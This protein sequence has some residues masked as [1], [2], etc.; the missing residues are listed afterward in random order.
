MSWCNHHGCPSN[1]CSCK[2]Y[3]EI[4]EEKVRLLTLENSEL[5]PMLPKWI[6]TNDRP[7]P[8]FSPSIVWDGADVAIGYQEPL[9]THWMPLP[10]PPK[11]TQ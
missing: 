9:T 7:A 8:R 6:S 1:Q 11:D 2:T 5:K 4:M 3:E 10:Q